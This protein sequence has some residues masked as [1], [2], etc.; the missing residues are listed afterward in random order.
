MALVEHVLKLLPLVD[1]HV[2]LSFNLSPFSL[3]DESFQKEFFAK[4]KESGIDPSR[5]II[6]LYERKTHHNLSGY[7]KTLNMFRAQGVRIAIDNFGS[8]NASMEYM[9]HFQFDIVQF[10]RGYVTKLDD[11][12][13]YSML[14]SLVQMA[15]D[16]DIITIAKWVDRPKQKEAL[17]TMGID[18][19]QGFGIAK[20]FSE[21]ELIQRY[22]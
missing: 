17:I 20:S 19:L 12:N 8:S 18:Y 21:R 6:E 1:N 11:K 2:C 9:K 3:R 14:N 4:L 5:I 16:L 22:N 13:T 7:L 10:D 15:K